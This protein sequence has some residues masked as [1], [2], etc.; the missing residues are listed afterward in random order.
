MFPTGDFLSLSLKPV[1]S[2]H[3]NKPDYYQ[4]TITLKAQN[5]NFWEVLS[6]SLHPDRK[7]SD[8][9]K[10]SK[11][12][13]SGPALWISNQRIHTKPHGLKGPS[14]GTLEIINNLVFEFVL[15]KWC[16]MGQRSRCRGLRARLTDGFGAT[17][18]LTHWCFRLP[19]LAPT[20]VQL[21]PFPHGRDVGTHTGDLGVNIHFMASPGGTWQ[22]CR[23][24][25]WETRGSMRQATQWRQASCPSAVQVLSLPWDRCHNPLGWP[26]LHGSGCRAVGKGLWLSHWGLSVERP[27][28]TWPTGPVTGRAH[29][30]LRESAHT[31][32]VFPCLTERDTK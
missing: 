13:E 15:C 22:S 24:S 11:I 25:R 6:N 10:H 31:C 5:Q 7:Q 3:S 1:F 17:T 21:P 18:F 4:A 20:Q 29:G 16:S 9:T 23:C 26:I 19:L 14:L 2:L 12:R 27:W 32:R 30:H 28:G 8:P